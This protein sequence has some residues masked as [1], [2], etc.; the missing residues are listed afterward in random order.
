MPAY[1]NMMITVTLLLFFMN[2]FFV[3][4]GTLPGTA[5]DF[6]ANNP[7]YTKIN[8]GLSSQQLN[9]MND[10]LN[11]VIADQNVFAAGGQDLNSALSARTSS[12]TYL[13]LFQNWLFGALNT[14]TLGISG[15]IFSGLSLFGSMITMFGS[16]FFGYLFWIGF[17]FPG[18]LAPIG[19]AIECFLFVV[20]MLGI[21][22]MVLRIFY[23]GTGVRG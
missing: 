18:M 5:G 6:N 15:Q 12:P 8:L 2:A 23:A 19:L 1:E 21:Y 17:F 7:G 20:Q 4:S 13:T 22:E 10:R 11:G 3:F 9:D 14:A 16:M